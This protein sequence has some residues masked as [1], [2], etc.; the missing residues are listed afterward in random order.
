MKTLDNGFVTLTFEQWHA[1]GDIF[2]QFDAEQFIDLAATWRINE[3]V[4]L[5]ISISDG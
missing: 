1:Q 3:Q 5:Q 4:S 2:Q